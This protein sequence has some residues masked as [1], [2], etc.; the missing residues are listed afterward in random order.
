MLMGFSVATINPY[1]MAMARKPSNLISGILRL[2][3]LRRGSA[4]SRST[5]TCGGAVA[6]SRSQAKIVLPH[7]RCENRKPL[8]RFHS[9][10]EVRNLDV[11]VPVVRNLQLTATA[12][13]SSRIVLV[14]GNE[15]KQRN[16]RAAKL[17]KAE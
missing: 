6:P 7:V 8:I 1:P 14:C 5:L 4:A 11:C 12:P 13:G 3:S 17:L 2:F 10:Q 9:V 15:W 16:G